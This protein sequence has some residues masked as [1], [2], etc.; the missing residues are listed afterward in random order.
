MI[1]IDYL[2]QISNRKISQISLTY[3][4]PL[5][6]QI[7]WDNRLIGIKGPKGVGK[8]TLLLQHI[9]ENFPDR[10]KVL[11]VSMDNMW[12]SS[13]DLFDLVEYHYTHGG[14]HIFLDEIHKYKKWQDCIKNIYDDYPDLHIVYT[15]SSILKLKSG[16]GD[17]SRRLRSYEMSG[18]SFR[19]YLL[20]EGAL[21][22]PE[23][24][25]DNILA[26]HV[27]IASDIVSKIK[28]LPFFETYLSNGYYPF[29]KEE[30]D[31][32]LSRVQE[33]ITQTIDMD[34]PAVEDVEYSTLQKLKKLLMILAVQVPFIPKMNELYQ[35]LDTNREQGLKLLNLLEQAK[36]ISMLKTPAKALKNMSSPEKLYLDNTNMMYSLSS[37]IEIGTVRETFFMNQ[38]AMT[39]TV[40]L[41]VKGDFKVDGKYLFEVGGRKKSFEQI[42]DEQN[43]FLA[44]DSIEIGNG[45]KI[46]LWLFGF[47]A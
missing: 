40:S 32:Y 29:Y 46:P 33:V 27:S 42:K 7:N 8:S 22:Y 23:I 4:R 2:Y 13:N 26:N 18:L 3:K 43:S 31:G 5:Y 45:N 36:L 41:P 28:I 44:I 11:Y 14:T 19:E 39:H 24:S 15:G 21:N 34:I 38:L 9:N 10:S 16:D 12:F 37:H 6:Y 20:F 17:L 47:L 25:L 30:G 1:T 35:E